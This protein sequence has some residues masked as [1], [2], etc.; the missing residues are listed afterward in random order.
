MAIDPQLLEILRC[1]ETLQPLTLAGDDLLERLNAKIAA[2]ELST[3]GGETVDEPVDGA[4][5]REDGEI[6]Y[7]IRDEIP[8]MLIEAGIRVADVA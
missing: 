6:L 1:P 3:V 8:E 4:L 5:L 2:G 7:V